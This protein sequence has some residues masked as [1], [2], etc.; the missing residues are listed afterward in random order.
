MKYVAAFLCGRPFEVLEGVHGL[1]FG[2][3]FVKPLDA[4]FRL[5]VLGLFDELG[6]LVLADGAILHGIALKN[7]DLDLI[8]AGEQ[9]RLPLFFLACFEGELKAGMFGADPL[10]EFVE[11][12]KLFVF[13]EDS[14]VVGQRLFSYAARPFT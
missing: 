12:W 13:R 9:E 11:R 7:G 3:V 6:D 10:R 1:Y 14:R 8:V 2:K 4:R 5:A